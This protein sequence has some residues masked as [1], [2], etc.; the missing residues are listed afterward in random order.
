LKKLQNRTDDEVD[1]I[2]SSMDTDKNGAINFNEFISA[3][4]NSNITKDYEKILSAFEYFDRNHDGLIDENEL[5]DALS[6]K[7]FSKI[8]IKVFEEVI[9]ECDLDKDGKISFDEFAQSVS[10][11]LE[12]LTRNNLM[13]SFELDK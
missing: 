1:E 4:L 6:G 11:Q 12:K 9:R 10:C 8:D 2:M 3:T 13:N 7:S 5:K